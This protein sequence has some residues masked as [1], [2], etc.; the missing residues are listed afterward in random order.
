M[1]NRNWLDLSNK[2][3][4][5]NSSSNRSHQAR[6][7]ASVLRRQEFDRAG[8]GNVPGKKQTKLDVSQT[9]TH[10]AREK[11]GYDQIPLKSPQNL[12]QSHGKKKKSKSKLE[13]ETDKTKQNSRAC[14]R[15]QSTLALCNQQGEREERQCRTS[16]F[17]KG[18]HCP[19][20]GPLHQLLKDC[21]S[22]AGPFKPPANPCQARFPL[23]ISGGTCNPTERITHQVI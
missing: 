5:S 10:C 7:S 16:G 8:D 20:S 21:L 14:K 13:K 19:L 4:Q 22:T 1:Y 12:L 15:S 2:C 17:N 9:P 3:L 23:S 6:Q 11:S 18:D